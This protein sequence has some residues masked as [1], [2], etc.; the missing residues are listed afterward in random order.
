MLPHFCIFA[1]HQLNKF[2][3]LILT[4]TPDAGEDPKVTRAKFFIRDLFLVS[5]FLA[6]LFSATLWLPCSLQF[7][8]YPFMLSLFPKIVSQ[9]R[10]SYPSLPSNLYSSY[11]CLWDYRCMSVGPARLLLLF[12]NLLCVA[13]QF[14]INEILCSVSAEMVHSLP[15]CLPLSPYHRD[16][17]VG[18]L[19][20]TP[21][22][23]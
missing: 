17:G 11:L 4:A 12:W 2:S 18:F 7:A 14:W 19:S 6:L 10:S 23:S 9:E 13:V 8:N 16:P 1:S 3:F 15:I 20:K 5:D 21:M 22:V